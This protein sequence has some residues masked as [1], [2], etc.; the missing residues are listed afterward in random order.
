MKLAVSNIGWTEAHDGTIAGRLRDAGADAL[1][2]APGRLFADPLAATLADAE[3]KREEF[4]AAGLPAVSM[5]SLLYGRPELTL[6]GSPE[7]RE[8]LLAHLE[9]IMALAGRLGCGPLVF[10]SPRN[11][12]RGGRSFEEATAEALPVLRRIGDIA[13]A[14]GTVFCLEANAAAYGCDF[15]TVLAEAT[16]VADATAH[17]GVGQVIDTGNMMM[18]GEAPAAA[19]AAIAH[20][21]H[22]HVSAPQLGPVAPHRAF[23]AEVV[24]AL[25]DAGYDGAVTLEMRAPGPEAADPLADLLRG[26]ETVRSVL[27][28]LGG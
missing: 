13:A 6:F 27:D 26:V 8:A 12:Q 4:A 5:Q 3:A 23:I 18:E 11:R 24:G 22:V 10:G 25:A 28:G 9:H 7:D 15:M 21:R 2:V 14:T 1:E 16:A 19:V 17:P 20:V